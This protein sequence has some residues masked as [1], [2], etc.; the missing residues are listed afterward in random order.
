ME[1]QLSDI[2]MIIY[3]TEAG[4]TIAKFEYCV[5]VVGDETM[6]KYSLYEVVAP[7]FGT[8]TLLDFYTAQIAVIKTNEGIL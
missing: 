3:G 7:D 5:Y 8:G 4:P 6:R 1:K 2:K